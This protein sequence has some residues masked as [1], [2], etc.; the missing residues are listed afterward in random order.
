MIKKIKNISVNALVGASLIIFQA[1]MAHAEYSDKVLVI[2]NEDVI[3]QSEFDFRLQSVMADLQRNGTKKPEGIEKQLL[4]GMVSDRLQI[5]EAERR[6]I[7]V[8]D[9]LSDSKNS[10]DIS[11]LSSFAAMRSLLSARV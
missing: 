11:I 8:S 2:V 4:D 10:S 3:T 1:D 9:Q 5:Q 6:G 7:T